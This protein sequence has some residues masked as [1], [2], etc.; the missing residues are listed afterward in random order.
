MHNPV[1]IHLPI[2][3]T[4]NPPT[5]APTHPACGFHA[6]GTVGVATADQRHV[7]GA[8]EAAQGLRQV[9]H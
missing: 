7:P 8:G 1:S 3:R 4:T 6:M 2:R 9:G 5:Q